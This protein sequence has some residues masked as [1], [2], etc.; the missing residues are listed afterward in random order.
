MNHALVLENIVKHFPGPAR[1]TKV[2]ALNDVSLSIDLGQTVALVG[3]SGSGKSTLGR[4]ALR[5]DR[6]TSGRIR[7]EDRDITR[8]AIRQLRRTARK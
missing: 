3:E 6:P 7:V 8:L 1:G 2:H 5:L 4:V